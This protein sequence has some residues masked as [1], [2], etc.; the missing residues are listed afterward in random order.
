MSLAL[1][2]E[3]L[4]EVL[5]SIAPLI[6]VVIV[7][8]FVLVRAPAEL[9]LRFLIGSLMTIAGL[10]L[11][12]LG[13]D[14]GVLPMGKFIGAEL[15]R[16]NSVLIILSATFLMGF[17]TTV[18]EP[19]VLVLSKQ[20]NEIS[21]GQISELSVLYFM[22]I[23]VGVF[24]AFAML[25]ILLGFSIS[26]MLII[27]YSLVVILTFIAPTKFIALSYDAGSVT[28]GA[29]TAPVMLAM[30]LGLSSVLANRSAL[31]DG[32]GILGFGSIGPIIIILLVGALFY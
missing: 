30:A 20:V 18:A 2:K 17:S 22:G 15:P 4:V 26:K 8:Q 14:I 3:K 25:R 12:F 5:R 10:I 11:F 31:S 13:I 6:A 7:F 19:D 29:L 27:A 28:T 16:R 21:H 9:F 1:L 23:G 32:F 24:A